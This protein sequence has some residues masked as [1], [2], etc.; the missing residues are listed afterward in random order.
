MFICMK[1][2]NYIYCD[3]DDVVA[4]AAHTIIIVIFNT[5]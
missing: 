3:D 4:A 1:Q 2:G 5:F